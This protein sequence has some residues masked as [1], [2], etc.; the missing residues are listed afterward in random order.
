MPGKSRTSFTKTTTQ[1]CV[2][3]ENR[4][5]AVSRTVTAT[6]G[7]D[8]LFRLTISPCFPTAE[9]LGREPAR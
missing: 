1:G 8:H 4:R 6:P 9:I 2:L 7:L 3:N 5:P